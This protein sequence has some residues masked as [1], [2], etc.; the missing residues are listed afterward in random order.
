LLTHRVEGLDNYQQAFADLGAS[1]AI[2]VF[3]EVAQG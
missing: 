3:V 2:K 1:G